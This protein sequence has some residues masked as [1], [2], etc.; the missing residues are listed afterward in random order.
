[1]SRMPNSNN[2]QPIPA[3]QS[4]MYQLR[5]QDNSA[6]RIDAN[7]DHGVQESPF[8]YAGRLGALRAR[9]AR[10]EA[11]GKGAYMSWIGAGH[12]VRQPDEDE[13]PLSWGEI[14]QGMRDGTFNPK[15]TGAVR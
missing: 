4:A 3:I 9:Q 2:I 8:G 6:T 10:I 5:C 15:I 12:G 13:T 14:R 1:M 11:I 7:W